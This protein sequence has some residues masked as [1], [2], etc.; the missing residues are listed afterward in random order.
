[1]KKDVIR[2]SGLVSA[3]AVFILLG[4]VLPNVAYLGHSQPAPSH[5]HSSHQPSAPQIPSSEDHAL[6]CHAG[7]AG[8]AGAQSTVGAIWVGEDSGLIAPVSETRAAHD[9]SQPTKPEAP[10]FPILEPPRAA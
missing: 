6:H 9:S 8:C 1:M 5:D 10:V 2:R 3:M 7:P 4:A